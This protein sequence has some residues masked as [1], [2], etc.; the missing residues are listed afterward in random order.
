[1]ID[2]LKYEGPDCSKCKEST[3]KIIGKTFDVEGA[4]MIGNIY[5]CDNKKCRKRKEAIEI[6]QLRLACLP[7]QAEEEG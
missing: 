7:P 6:Y 4:G 1:M 5:M 3:K 2:L